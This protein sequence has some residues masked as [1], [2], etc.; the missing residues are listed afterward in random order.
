MHE[1]A[2]RIWEIWGADNGAPMWTIEVDTTVKSIQTSIVKWRGVDR[3][4]LVRIPSDMDAAEI[5]KDLLENHPI[6]DLSK[7]FPAV[8][9]PTMRELAQ[10]CMGKLFAWYDGDIPSAFKFGQNSSNLE[11]YVGIL[12]DCSAKIC[13]VDRYLADTD[14]TILL[15]IVEIGRLLESAKWKLRNADY[16][17]GLKFRP[18]TAKATEERQHIARSWKKRLHRFVDSVDSADVPRFCESGEVN[19][20]EFAKMAESEF[21]F[22]KSRRSIVDAIRSHWAKE[23]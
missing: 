21:L 19:F 8:N 23:N 17:K 10:E 13:T 1:V 6:P 2:R 9:D 3:A 7:H 12:Q 16:Q 5:G 22:E 4:V 15:T 14:R 20:T 11:T 18:K